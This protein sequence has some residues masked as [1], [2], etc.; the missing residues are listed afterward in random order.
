MFQVLH[1]AIEQV[2]D[3]ARRVRT[4]PV[5][6]CRRALAGRG[7]RRARAAGRGGQ[8]ARRPPGGGHRLVEAG[9][10]A[11][12]RRR[13]VGRHHRLHRRRCR[14]DARHVVAVGVVAVAPRRRC[15]PARCRSRRSTPSPMP[16]RS[17]RA[18]SSTCSSGRQHDGVR[19]L[20]NECARVKAAACV[21]ENERYEQIRAARSLRSWTDADGAGRIDIRGPVDATAKVLAALAPFEKALFEAARAEDRQE[22]HD[23]LAF[24]AIVALAEAPDRC[25]ERRRALASPASCASTTRRWSGAGPNRARCAR[26]S[27]RARSRCRWRHGCS[28]TR[29]SRRSW[30][31]A[32]TSSRCRTSAARSRLGC[33]PRSRRCI[34]ECDI[35]GCHVT[36]NLEI[37]HNQPVEEFGKTEL[38]NLGRLCLHHH[39]H[40]HRH[41]LRL[42]GPPGRMW[43]V[44]PLIP[45]RS[46]DPEGKMAVDER[47]RL[48]L[49]DAAKRAFGDD[50]GITLMELLPPVGWADVATKQD[51]LALEPRF[52]AIGRETRSASR[53]A[54]GRRSRTSSTRCL[55]RSGRR[56]GS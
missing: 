3:A 52:V 56:R 42:E 28:T 13:L 23:A 50:A 10:H 5:R 27:A 16:R 33:A 14:G 48:Q 4:R 22:R 45:L 39:R 41:R 9:R 37:D 11:P 30:S 15:G 12:R 34:R 43:F 31:T 29:S 40:K 36:S 24:D 35:E 51:L 6:R 47:G 25:S 53:R 46:V 49:A 18:P 21:D 54:H 1:D 19:G 2:R 8:G 7:V 17:I 20:R 32:P 44:L 26:S 38:C 55:A